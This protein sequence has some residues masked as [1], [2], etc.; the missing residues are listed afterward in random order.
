MLVFFVGLQYSS[1]DTSIN[2]SIRLLSGHMQVQ[3]KGYNDKP[4]IRLSFPDSHSLRDSISKLPFVS[5]AAIRSI[6]YA[7]LSS[8]NRSYGAQ[9]VGV[10]ATPNFKACR[11][12]RTPL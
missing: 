8:E 6:G 11:A 12:R 1:Y 10:E 5:A 3:R 2:A 7:I 9:I 4:E